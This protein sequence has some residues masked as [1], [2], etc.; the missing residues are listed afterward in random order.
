MNEKIIIGDVY[1]MNFER[2]ISIRQNNELTQASIAKIL[3]VSRSAY[4][5]WEINKNVIPLEKLNDFCNYFDVSM[6]YVVGTSDERTGNFNK[7]QLNKKEIGKRL[8]LTRKELKLTQEK[9]AKKFNTTHSA[10]SAYENGVTMIP[11]I[12][13][14]EFVKMS[15][16]SLD[17]FCGRIA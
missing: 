7:N 3:N 1:I 11:T 5:L 2:I 16:K 17:W 9:L 15:K 4:S 6:D 12:F 14:V 10:I 13:I 8:K